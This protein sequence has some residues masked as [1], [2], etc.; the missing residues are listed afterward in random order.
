MHSNKINRLEVGWKLT[1]GLDPR[2]WLTSSPKP[3]KHTADELVT[4]RASD[5]AR[6]IAIIA[7]SGS[8]KSYFLGRL[9][10]EVLLKTK[11]RCLVLDPSGDFLQ[12]QGVQ[13]PGPWSEAGYNAV[14]GKGKLPTEANREEFHRVWKDI[15][16]RVRSMSSRVKKAKPLRLSWLSLSAELLAADVSPE[17]RGEVQHCHNFVQA[18][19]EFAAGRSSK[20]EIDLLDEAEKLLQKVNAERD[21]I[22]QSKRNIRKRYHFEEL[23]SEKARRYLSSY[24]WSHDGQWLEFGK[25][26]PKRHDRM[27]VTREEK[28]R[29]T[30]ELALDTVFRVP[31]YITEEAIRFYF[32][33]AAIYKSTALFTTSATSDISN[34]DDSRRLEVID[35]ASIESRE[36]RRLAV[37]S[38][39]RTEWTRARAAW[40]QALGKSL[41]DDD[42]VPCFVVLD[43]A[44]N[45]IRA[46]SSDKADRALL[47]Q[48]RT[49]AAEGRKFGLFLILAS[50]RP[51]KLDR[52]IISECENRIVMKVGSASVLEVTNEML[53]LEDV[54]RKVL[55]KCLEL[56]LGGGMLFGPW[57]ENN[58]IFFCSAARR[59]IEGGRNL[60][61]KHWATSVTRKLRRKSSTRST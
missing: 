19:G 37:S 52:L 28:E 53:G 27:L 61:K 9:L 3:G 8:G 22:V 18:V 32:G 36:M 13:D 45:L 47:E 40:M 58:P 5:I 29:E 20:K 23:A 51:D 25:L 54:P 10:E 17:L 55:E 44:H 43:E 57:S 46:D 39:L 1:P 16:V 6:H 2:Y 41:A 59:T 48:F 33:R 38:I 31:H 21:S 7:Q 12:M 4:I 50:Q 34:L 60:N 14:L 11:C 35:L 30:L 49:I 56:K 26:P 15:P 24:V 42:R